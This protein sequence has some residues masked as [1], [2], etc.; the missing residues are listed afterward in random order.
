VADFTGLMI[1]SVPITNI[2]GPASA[3]LAPATGIQVAGVDLNTALLRLA[4]GNPL[5]HNIGMAKAGTGL[6]AIFGE[7]PTSLP[8][9]GK[10]YVCTGIWASGASG[11][12]QFVF[13]LT[14]TTAWATSV[15]YP[16]STSGSPAA[17]IQDSG[18]VPSGATQVRYTGTWNNA[19]GDTGSYTLTN[20]AASATALATSLNITLSMPGSGTSARQ[21]TYTFKVEFLNASNAVISTTTFT[22]ELISEGSA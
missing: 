13:N 22:V 5:G 11:S 10:K 4:D 15:T 18:A 1:A 8:I 12:V 17:G 16:G 6:S 7:P 14:S 3:T 2:Y 19:S 20:S 21:T 9:N